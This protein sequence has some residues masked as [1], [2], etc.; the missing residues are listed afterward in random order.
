MQGLRRHKM[1]NQKSNTNKLGHK[2]HQIALDIDEAVVRDIPIN[3]IKVSN[4]CLRDDYSDIDPLAESIKHNGLLQPG[5]AIE[6]KDGSYTLIYGSRRLEA[7]KILGKQTFRCRV[8]KATKEK[9]AILS[10]AENSD[11]EHMHPVEQ[12]RK[13][14]LM[15]KTFG[16]KESDL[17]EKIGWKQ[18]TI[19]E[20]VGV[21][22]LDE[23]ILK[24]VDNR[25]ESSF[26]Y[27]H[28]VALSKLVRSKRFNAKI[29]VQ[30]LFNKTIKNRI[31][32]SELKALVNIFKKGGF[33][34]LPDQLRT[35]LLQDKHMTAAM[36]VLYLAPESIIEGNDDNAN[37]KRQLLKN[38][39][40]TLLKDT[41]RQAVKAKWLYERT[42]QKLL[43]LIGNKSELTDKNKEVIKSSHQILSDCI[44]VIYNKL[45]ICR[46][47]FPDLAKTNHDVLTR[48]CDEIEILKVKLE[49]FSIS[50][51]NA[52]SKDELKQ[53]A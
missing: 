36:A 12:A 42:K 21:L 17:A 29:E 15:M 39:D 7:H 28:A 48:L 49:K 43:D 27:T 13:I 41:I 16:W 8:I 22:D 33:D 53:S 4:F 6:N 30:Q 44:S 2:K 20:Y 10:F 19:S 40:K 50:A 14:Q 3:K 45:D 34:C 46:S 51:R 26:R 47:E 24:Q 5:A 11:T 31:L 1:E 37:C 52:L 32:C 38:L 18:N 25:P 35:Y 9:A 23:D